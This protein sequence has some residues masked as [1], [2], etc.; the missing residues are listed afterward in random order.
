[1]VSLKKKQKIKIILASASPRRKIL[2]RVLLKNFGLNFTVKPSNIVEY[3]PQK[4]KNF[5]KFAEELACMKA[6]E[7]AVERKAIVIGADT[8][9][10]YKNKVLG[11]PASKKE[12]VSMLKFLSGKQ[13]R[14][15]TGLCIVD[16][17]NRLMYKTYEMTKVSFRRLDEKE[18]RYYVS[19]GSPMDKAGA[20]G[21]QDDFGSTFV[22]KITGDYFNVVGLPVVKT[23]LGLKAILEKRK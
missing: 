12:A 21:I 19:T 18:I 17:E 3:I 8:I 9:V 20:Y 10:V 16:S 2:L 5:G 11:K 23:Y 7:I 15:Y 1:M 6:A 13:H 4:I 14:V 22:E